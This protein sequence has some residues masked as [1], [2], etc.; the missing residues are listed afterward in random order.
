MTSAVSLSILDLVPFTSG[1]GGRDVVTD[2]L[3]LAK[4]ADEE[5]YARLWYAEHHNSRTFASSAT[6]VLIGRAAAATERIRVGSGG[7]MLP[8]H[9]V[10]SVA[11]SFGTLEAM[12]PGRIDLGLGRAP[13][14]DLTTAALLRRGIRDE[15]PTAFEDGIRAL[16]WYFGDQAEPAPAQTRGVRARVAEGAAVPMWV[17]G[18]SVA[19]A[20]LAA[21]LGLPFAVASHFAP[22]EL[23]EASA[24]Y[25]TSFVASDVAAQPQLMIGANVMV[26]P[27]REEAQY[28]FTSHLQGF[29]NVRRGTGGDLPP[30]VA[31]MSDVWSPSE[32]HMVQAALK[33]SAV[34][35]PDDVVSSLLQT[36]RATGAQEIILVCYSHDPALRLRTFQLLAR[37]WPS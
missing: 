27:T 2:A 19:G 7:V 3:E 22:F 17:L 13:G 8:N 33:V 23:I 24:K 30:P 15:S 37:A 1:E 4:V 21:D 10:L 25:R 26:A 5:G 14:T 31:N 34:G 18:S 36:A 20:A 6:D 28:L 9:S 11:E 16:R 35:T 32:A 29:L 12:F